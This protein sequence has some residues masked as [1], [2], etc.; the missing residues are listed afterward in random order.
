VQLASRHCLALGFLQ[1]RELALFGGDR[2]DV[3]ADSARIDGAS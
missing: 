1:L 3:I 2:L